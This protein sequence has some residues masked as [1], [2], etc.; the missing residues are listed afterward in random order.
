MCQWLTPWA[1]W[2][3][4][5]LFYHRRLCLLNFTDHCLLAT[6]LVPHATRAT[7]RRDQRGQVVRRP[8]RWLLHATDRSGPDLDERPLYTH[9]APNQAIPAH[10]SFRSFPLAAAHPLTVLSWPEA[11]H[12]SGSRRACLMHI[13]RNACSP[14]A[15]PNF[16]EFAQAV[17]YGVPGTPV[18]GTL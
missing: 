6:I 1:N 2:L 4:L 11:L 17:R 3:C 12:D 18:P 9:C 10:R 8:S 7:Y 16:P 5:A 14:V 15:F 13:S